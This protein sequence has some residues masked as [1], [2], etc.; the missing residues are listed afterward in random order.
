MRNAFPHLHA[1][2]QA[3]GR[4]RD[5]GFWDLNIFCIVVRLC[6]R[7]GRKD[8]VVGLWRVRVYQPK[9]G[10]GVQAGVAAGHDEVDVCERFWCTFI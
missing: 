9:G 10:R 4:D 1:C 6:K 3:H 8:G 7:I 5:A 2:G